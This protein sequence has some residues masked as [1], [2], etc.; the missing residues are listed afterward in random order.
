MDKYISDIVEET[1]RYVYLHPVRC[2]HVFQELDTDCI[3]SDVSVRALDR[4]LD[5]ALDETLD[6]L[7][8][9]K[10]LRQEL[11]EEI[12][13][14]IQK[15]D[16]VWD[17]KVWNGVTKLHVS[18]DG[19]GNTDNRGGGCGHLNLPVEDFQWDCE[20]PNGI[21]LR[22]LS[23]AVYRMKGSKYDYWYELF[24]GIQVDI[25]GDLA[26]VKAGFGYGS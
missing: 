9:R 18:S 16:I 25:K 5:E 4:A 14:K 20:N 1:I 3:K 8:D 19:T 10:Q 22:N 21:T 24:G 13:P 12:K 17:A 11:A 7:P 23:E 15:L 6:K 2:I 26:T